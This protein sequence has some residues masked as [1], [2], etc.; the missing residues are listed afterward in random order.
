M[1]LRKTDVDDKELARCARNSR[2]TETADGW[3]FVTREGLNMGPYESMFD[4]ELSASLL[5]TRL[6]QLE[7]GADPKAVIREYSNDPS[8][9]IIR[10]PA[11]RDPMSLN[12]IRRKQRREARAVAVQRAW[13]LLTSFASVHHKGA[14]S[15]G[16]RDPRLN[17]QEGQAARARWTTGRTSAQAVC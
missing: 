8:N 5:V 4:A 3:Y 12:S 2:F 13:S 11:P 14:K 1:R 6:A 16:S 9:P 7:K 15:G 10:N 17:H